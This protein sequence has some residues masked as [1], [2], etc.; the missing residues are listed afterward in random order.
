MGGLKKSG[1]HANFAN[2][3]AELCSWKK[4][5]FH[6]NTIYYIYY[7]MCWVIAVGN[8]RPNLAQ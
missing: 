4:L 2:K 1:G 5:D 7:L 8:G 6:A 3:A